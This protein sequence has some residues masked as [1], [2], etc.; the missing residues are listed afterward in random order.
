VQPVQASPRAACLAAARRAERI[1]GLPHSL[2]VAIALSESGLHA[3]AL[4]INGR[5]HFPE[6]PAEA[7]A[8]LAEP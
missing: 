8:M 3:H 5:A 7:R 2:M 6:S 1:H 4:N